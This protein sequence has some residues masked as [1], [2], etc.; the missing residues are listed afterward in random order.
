[1]GDDIIDRLDD[2]ILQATKERSHYYVE[3]VARAARN[4]IIS[5][6]TYVTVLK[7]NMSLAQEHLSR[8]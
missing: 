1:M 3:S 6:R 5:L 2:L 8:G 7:E 4:E